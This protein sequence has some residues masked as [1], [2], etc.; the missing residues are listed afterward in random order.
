MKKQS[1]VAMSLAALAAGYATAEAGTL[2]S[3]PE[4]L[5]TPA[6]EILTLET[7]ARGVQIYQCSARQDEPTRFEWTFKAPEADLFD[8]T[9]RKI[10]KHYAGPTWE[11]DD[12]SKVVGVLKARDNGPDAD[13]IPWLLLGAKSTAGSGVFSRTTSIQRVRTV[14]GIPPTETC[15]EAQAGN[16]SRVGYSATYYF[17]V[18]KP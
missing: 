11:S 2:P 12:G 9:G 5:R 10:G 15:S 7:A 16:V 4:S 14:G 8:T 18:A 3:I 1:L 17:Y 13:A 6:A